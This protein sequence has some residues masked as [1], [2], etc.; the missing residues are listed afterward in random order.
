MILPVVALALVITY[1]ILDRSGV[2]DELA[3]TIAESQGKTVS[4]RRRSQEQGESDLEDDNRLEV[5]QDF[6][7]NL[8]SSDEKEE[9]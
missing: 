4:W 6:I 9:E 1:L 3:D 5:F 8:N 2:I 7:D